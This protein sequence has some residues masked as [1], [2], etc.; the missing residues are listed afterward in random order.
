MLFIAALV[1]NCHSSMAGRLLVV[2][3]PLC[4]SHLMA[5]RAIVAE[6]TEERGHTVVV[7]CSSHLLSA[8]IK[9]QMC[10]YICAGE[11]VHA[12]CSIL[13]QVAALSSSGLSKDMQHTVL[14]PA[15]FCSIWQPSQTLRDF[16]LLGL[17]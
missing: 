9:L 10:S 16:R 1:S 6:L 3:S 17:Q 14:M 12:P 8:Y 5:W 15:A 7:I 11:G 4:R 13:G 2:V